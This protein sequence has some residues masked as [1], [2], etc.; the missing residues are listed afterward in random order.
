MIKM[1]LINNDYGLK[2]KV[3][4]LLLVIIKENYFEL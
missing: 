4:S 3:K 2:I 1:I